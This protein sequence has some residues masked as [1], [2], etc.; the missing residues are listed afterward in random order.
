M[1]PRLRKEILTLIFLGL[2]LF[3]VGYFLPIGFDWER[4]YSK[5]IY[6][7][8]W[9]PWTKPLVSLLNQ[10]AVFAIT[11]LAIGVRAYRYRPALAPIALA[12]VSLPVLWVLHLGTLD[13]LS[14]LGMLLLP[15]GA[16]LVLIKPQVASFALLAS[17]RSLAVAVSWILFSFLIWGFWPLGF[18]EIFS[19]DWWVEWQQDIALFPY[20]L[21]LALPLLWFSRGDQDLL[22]AAGSLATPHLFPYH[23]IVLM[24]ALARM[25]WYWMVAAWVVTWTPIF[26]ANWWGPLFWHVGNLASVVFWLGI[27]YAPVQPYPRPER[28]RLF[29][30]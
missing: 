7:G 4:Q 21:A 19:P 25:R 13:G 27:Y 3:I 11:V 16:P 22:M 5:G 14:I 17:R 29:P 2:L 18:L 26:A 10:P 12:L 8:F 6:P 15:L 20:G 24:P 9:M 28:F 30:E 23:F 1:K